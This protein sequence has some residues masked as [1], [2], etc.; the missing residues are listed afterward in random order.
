MAASEQASALLRARL[1][2]PT[3][4][5]SAFKSCPTANFSKLK[6][7]ITSSISEGCN[8][9]VLL[10]GPRGSGKAAVVDLVLEDLKLEYT[11]SISMVRLNGLLHSD[12]NCA[13][14]E[15]ARQLCMEHK[16][17]FSKSASSDE[18]NEFIIDM[19]KECGLAHKSLVFVLDEFDLFTQGKQRLLY[20]L[21]DAMQTYTSQ[22]VLI[23]LSCRL[24]ADQL[25]EKRVRSR[26]SHRKLL[27]L[28]PSENE[29]KSLLEYLL[30]L[31]KDLN[32]PLKYVSEFNSR[33]ANI[34]NDRKF[35]EIL[36][37]V[38]DAY[39]STSDLI[40]F[41]F[42]ALSHMDIESGFL[43]L[44]NF[45]NAYSCTTIQPKFNSLHDL[46]IVELYLLICMHRL[47]SKEEISYNFNSIIK[48]YKAIQYAYKTSDNYANS[49]CLRAFEHLLDRE[50]IGF[51]DNKGRNNSIESRP[52]KLLVSSHEL[53]NSLKSNS[54]C[55]G[56]MQKLLD[57]ERYM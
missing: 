14:K 32:L 7:L 4:V 2:S 18:N 11:D 41:L 46:S 12:D 27:F 55:P 15:I 33:L 56:N 49:V 39:G 3:F 23:G 8:N 35:K 28:P 29:R 5:R 43:T 31:P 24:D 38:M 10:L 25:L 13:L 16:L 21:F 1:C 30:Y 44:D 42:I 48:E 40:R 17:S 6:F 22:S 19:L 50:L 54:M 45:K 26:F 34:F 9:S 51:T 57:R 47:E 20:S 53:V 37:S 36:N 52:V